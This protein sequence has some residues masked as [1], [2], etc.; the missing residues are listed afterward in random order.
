MN[1]Y[2]KLISRGVYCESCGCYT[3]AESGYPTLCEGCDKASHE[4]EIEDAIERGEEI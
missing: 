1:E 3:G 2:A 4:A